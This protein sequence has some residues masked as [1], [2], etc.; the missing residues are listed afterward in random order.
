MRPTSI[1]PAIKEPFEFYGPDGSIPIDTVYSRMMWPVGGLD[2]YHATQGSDSGSNILD[3]VPVDVVANLTLTHLILGTR[4]VVQL[5]SL[6]YSPRTFDK[7]VADVRRS[8]PPAWLPKIPTVVFTTDRT[9]RQGQLAQFYKIATTD[10]TFDNGKSRKLLGLEGPLSVRFEGHDVDDFTRGRIERIFERTM[11]MMEAM[12]MKAR[13]KRLE[14][15]IE[16]RAKAARAR[17]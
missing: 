12:E 10:W 14:E 16:G 4:G 11:P 15:D 2:V 6:C 8:L 17:L 7:V 1:G 3:E 13:K 9:K 5:G